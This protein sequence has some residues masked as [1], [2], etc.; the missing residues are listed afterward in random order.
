[1]AHRRRLGWLGLQQGDAAFAAEM[2][3]KRVFATATGA[4]RR[5]HNY[6]ITK[7]TREVAGQQFFP[8]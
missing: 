6:R 7:D 8:N 3:V 1:L 4:E 5:Y 2:V